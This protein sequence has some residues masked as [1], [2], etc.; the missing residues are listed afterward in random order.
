MKD[1]CFGNLS[2]RFLLWA[3]ETVLNYLVKQSTS[4][5]YDI[6]LHDE[7]KRIMC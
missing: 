2:Y 4:I 5:L 1:K 7:T 6:G 3:R